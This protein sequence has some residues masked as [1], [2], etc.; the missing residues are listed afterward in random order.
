MKLKLADVTISIDF[1]NDIRDFVVAPEYG[2]FITQDPADVELEVRH[3]DTSGLDLGKLVIDSKVGWCLYRTI[4]GKVGLVYYN[5]PESD[6]VLTVIFAPDFLSGVVYLGARLND[7]SLHY[8]LGVA[9]D[10]F[11]MMYL[12]SRGRGVLL[13][14]CGVSDNGRGI[15]FSGTSGAGKSTSALLWKQQTGVALLNDDHVIVRKRN[16]RF[17]M[18][19]TPWCGRVRETSSMGVPLDQVYVLR[20]ADSNNAALLSPAQAASKLLV[21]SFSPFWDADGMAFT[22]DFLGQL[23]QDI[24]C[25]DLGFVPDESVVQFVRCIQSG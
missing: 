6:P 17:W 13:H 4:T 24:P 7:E 10:A 25:Y 3:S 22:L 14:A 12:L 11:L 21:R 1:L 5:Q 9:F 20:H 16:G 19:G 18:Y 15:L 8:P 23:S 2:P